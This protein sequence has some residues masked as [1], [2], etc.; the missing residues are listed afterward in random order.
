MR[1]SGT[2]SLT[3]DRLER[4][5]F[6]KA[7]GLLI[8]VRHVNEHGF[9]RGAYSKP[10]MHVQ[11]GGKLDETSLVVLGPEKILMGPLNLCAAYAAVDLM[12]KLA[13]F[14]A[15]RDQKAKTKQAAVAV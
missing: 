1:G 9:D 7:T 10:S 13:G 5:R 6:L 2:G 3:L 14:S 12:R 15:L 8:S 11:E 4:K